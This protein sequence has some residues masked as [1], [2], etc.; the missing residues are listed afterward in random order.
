MLRPLKPG[1]GP[2]R[3]WLGIDYDLSAGI[4]VE[5]SGSFLRLVY[6]G[7]LHLAT[8]RTEIS[9]MTTDQATS[10]TI[11]VSDPEASDLERPLRADARRNRERLVTAARAVFAEHGSGAPMEAIAKEA[12]VGVG[13]LYRHFPTRP[14]IVEAVYVTDI[15]ELADA[16]RRVTSELEPW[17]AVVEFFDA[18]MRYAQAKAVLLSEL[19]RSFEK[20]PEFKSRAREQINGAFEL[21][22]GRAQQAGV[23]RSDVVPADL[24]Q[25]IGPTCSNTNVSTEQTRGLIRIVLDGLRVGAVNS[26]DIDRSGCSLE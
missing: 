7:T 18:F 13:T 17:P 20:H 2:L 1:R 11:Q 12:G 5:G 14:D 6:G 4:L 19:Q 21:V 22:I 3:V 15:Q 23:I 8:P 26:D 25:M 9:K 10:P 16:A 24:W